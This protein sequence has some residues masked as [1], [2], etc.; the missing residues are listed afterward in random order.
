MGF[1]PYTVGALFLLL[2]VIGIGISRG[3]NNRV[4]RVLRY[5]A[6]LL[7]VLAWAAIKSEWCIWTPNERRVFISQMNSL[8]R[9]NLG[10]AAMLSA[11]SSARFGSGRFC[12]GI[13]LPNNVAHLD[14]DLLERLK[15]VPK[16]MTLIWLIGARATTVNL[17]Y[18]SLFVL[19]AEESE[20]V[21]WVGWL[22]DSLASHVKRMDAT[23]IYPEAGRAND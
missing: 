13:I 5:V 19:D 3:T 20:S 9:P 2:A 17:R 7:V 10:D 15:N 8:E 12:G 11:V 4:S 18:G 23:M 6:V 1:L 21:I 22:A 16:D 14:I